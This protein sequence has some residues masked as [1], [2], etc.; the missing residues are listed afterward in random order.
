MRIRFQVP[1]T[2]PTPCTTGCSRSGTEQLRYMSL[3]FQEP[4][5]VTLA[6]LADNAFVKDTNGYV[7]L[8]VGTGATIP[9]WITAANG[10]TLLDLTAISGYKKLYSLF[11]RNVLPASTFYCSGQVV[12]YNTTVYTPFGGLMGDYLPVVDYPTAASLPPTAVALIGPKSCDRFPNGRPAEAPNCSVVASSPIMITSIPAPSPTASQIA[13][14]PQPPIT[15]SG[16]GF[17]L[18]PRGLPYTGDTPFLEII[19]A[20]QKWSAGYPGDLCNVA[21]SNWLSNSI[22]LVANLQNGLCPLVA[23]DELTINVWNPQSGSGPATATV[24]VA[25]N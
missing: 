15:I 6:S 7:T 12:P 21:I 20:T 25:P 5:A 4:K 23:G 8:I 17:G 13:A 18:L 2:P 3:S 24:T 19:N 1:T 9:S 11:L 22:S 16:G 10:Y 14:Q